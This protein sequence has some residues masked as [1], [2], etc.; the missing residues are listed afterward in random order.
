VAFVRDHPLAQSMRQHPLRRWAWA[1]FVV[2]FPAL[3]R[4][5]VAAVEGYRKLLGDAG[6]SSAIT[7]EEL[8]DTPGAIRGGTAQILWE[9]ISERRL[10]RC[11][12]KLDRHKSEQEAVLGCKHPLLT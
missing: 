9:R 12:A 1:R 2:V 10:H 7:L 3:N 4:S 5:S 8:L 11:E 6:T